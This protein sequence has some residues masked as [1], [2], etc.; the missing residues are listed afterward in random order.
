[1]L[2]EGTYNTEITDIDEP[3]KESPSLTVWISVYVIKGG[4]YIG[5]QTE[6]S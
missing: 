4:A 5:K 1:M 6:D 2:R 3:F